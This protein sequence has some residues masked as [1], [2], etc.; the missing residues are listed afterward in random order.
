M[1]GGV[2]QHVKDLFL[3]LQG[4]YWE[5]PIWQPFRNDVESLARSLSQYASYLN[6]KNKQMKI[7]HDQLQPIRDVGDHL[8]FVFLPVSDTALIT[9]QPLEQ[10]L[11]AKECY[12]SVRMAEFAPHEGRLKTWPPLSLCTAHIFTWKQHWQP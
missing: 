12:Q 10:A 4:S 2:L 3:C 11:Q 6:E 7:A 9:F 8:T 5:R 1:S